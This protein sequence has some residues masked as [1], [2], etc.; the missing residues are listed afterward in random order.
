VLKDTGKNLDR[1]LIGGV[2]GSIGGL[3]SG[4]PTAALLGAAAGSAIRPL[5][6]IVR[7]ALT[8]STS[9]SVRASLHNHFLV[10]NPSDAEDRY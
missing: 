5:Y 9:S 2:T 1:V 7:G 3:L 10:L 4:S 8:S 6:D